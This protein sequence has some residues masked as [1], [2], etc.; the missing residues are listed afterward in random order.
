MTKSIFLSLSLFFVSG[1][2]FAAA[3]ETEIRI[4]PARAVTI[5]CIQGEKVEVVTGSS[6]ELTLVRVDGTQV[7]YEV[8]ADDFFVASCD[9]V[10]LKGL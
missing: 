4:R 3:N 1:T 9:N 10:V 6:D 5:N 2:A 7:K 8:Y